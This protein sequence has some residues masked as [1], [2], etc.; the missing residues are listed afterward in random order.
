MKCKHCGDQISLNFLD[1]WVDSHLV[2]PQYCRSDKIDQNSD[3]PDHY[4]DGG[5]YRHEPE[6]SKEV[7]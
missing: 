7:S 2:F 6:L 1:V 3:R 4:N 5:G